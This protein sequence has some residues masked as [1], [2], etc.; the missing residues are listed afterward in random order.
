MTEAIGVP[1][2]IVAMRLFG[3]PDDELHALT[4]T[5][6]SSLPDFTRGFVTHWLGDIVPALSDFGTSDIT[7]WWERPPD[8]PE[9]VSLAYEVCRQLTEGAAASGLSQEF[10]FVPVGPDSQVLAA[11]ITVEGGRFTITLPAGTQFTLAEQADLVRPSG[12]W[13]GQQVV[14]SSCLS[15]RPRRSV[16]RG[17]QAAHLMSLLS[18]IRDVVLR[19]P[20]ATLPP[21]ELVFPGYRELL[22]TF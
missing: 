12:G 13:F 22:K 14:T 10:V 5:P 9:G 2:S 21:T 17:Q 11:P 3:Q 7:V 20:E 18:K 19:S 15:A 1:P 4:A 16:T 8:S 6:G